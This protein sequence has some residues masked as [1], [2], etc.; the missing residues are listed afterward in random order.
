M[1]MSHKS[2]KSF[3]VQCGQGCRTSASRDRNA[4]TPLEDVFAAAWN[5]HH[6]SDSRDYG[7][8]RHGLHRDVF[9]KLG[10]ILWR[11]LEGKRKN[12]AKG[13]TSIR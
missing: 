3:F 7:R 12:V 8:N 5:N 1:P 9:T 6:A 11:Y 13:V 2:E 10:Q 4:A